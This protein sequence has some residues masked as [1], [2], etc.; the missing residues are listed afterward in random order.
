MMI[1]E[2]KDTPLNFVSRVAVTRSP[3]LG[4]NL[5]KPSLN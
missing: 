4:E 2:P 1:N 3:F 5:L